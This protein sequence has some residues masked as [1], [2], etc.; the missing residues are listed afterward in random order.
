MTDDQRQRR[1]HNSSD[2]LCNAEM[3]DRIIT[4]DDP[5]TERQNMQWKKQNSLGPKKARMS[6]SQFR[7]MLVCFFVQKGQFP[8]NALPKDE[9]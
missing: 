5:E 9:Q 7:T 3:F 8:I 4:G 2:L 6:R 1:L